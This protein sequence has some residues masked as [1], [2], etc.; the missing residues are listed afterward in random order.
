MFRLQTDGA[1]RDGRTE[2]NDALADALAS[3]RKLYI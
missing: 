2:V 3:I 1:L